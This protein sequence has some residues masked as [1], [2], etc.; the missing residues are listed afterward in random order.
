MTADL[1]AGLQRLRPARGILQ[2][3]LAGQQIAGQARLIPL[4][5][6]QLPGQQRLR[7]QLATQ[8]APLLRGKR[9]ERRQAAQLFGGKGFA[10]EDFQAPLVR[11]ECS[12]H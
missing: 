4:T 12:R 6:Q 5:K 3:Q 7:H 2:L 10:H 1:A 8:L 9:V 11:P